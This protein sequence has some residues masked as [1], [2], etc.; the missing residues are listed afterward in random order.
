M[1]D[2]LQSYRS[3]QT[4]GPNFGQFATP[5]TGSFAAP[6]ASGPAS[7]PEPPPPAPAPAAAAPAMR[8]DSVGGEGYGGGGVDP[9][10]SGYGKTDSIVG[11][12]GLPGISTL[13]A[14]VNNP[15]AASQYESFF[16]A[17]PTSMA[18]KISDTFDPNVVNPA[19]VSPDKGAASVDQGKADYGFGDMGG[20]VGGSAQGGSDK[21]DGGADASAEAGSSD[22]PNSGDG[23]EGGA[24]LR[25]GGAIPDTKPGLAEV[26]AILHETEFV[27]RPEI[28]Q[29]IGPELLTAVNSGAIPPEIMRTAIEVLLEQYAPQYLQGDMPIAGPNGTMMSGEEAGGGMGGEEDMEGME[30]M[31]GQN[32]VSGPSSPGEIGDSTP[33]SGDMPWMP[34]AGLGPQAQLASSGGKPPAGPPEQKKPA[35]RYGGA[36]MPHQKVVPSGY[37]APLGP[38]DTLDGWRSREGGGMPHRMEAGM[39]GGHRQQRPPS[40]LRQSGPG[41]QKGPEGE[42]K[43]FPV[44][45]YRPQHERPPEYR[46]GGHVSAMRQYGGG[47]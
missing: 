25:T 28:A 29:A 16:G 17:K 40:A 46:Q 23:A 45:S 42:K 33:P 21:G 24:K 26:P 5:D 12:L 35:Y 7:I 37:E 31:P 1:V 22:G 15:L 8:Q 47:R 34:E 13:A 41:Q 14:M 9:A 38:E 27:F 20:T 18:S 2:F 10:T 6:V 3:R 4:R 30:G 19:A 36:A 44:P 39:P 11:M 43:R 32:M